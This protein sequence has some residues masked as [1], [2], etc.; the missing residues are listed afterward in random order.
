MQRRLL[1]AAAEQLGI[2]VDSAHVESMLAV[3]AGDVK[4]CE[5][6]GTW[7]V[8]RSFR[9]LRIEPSLPKP[10]NE[11]YDLPLPVPGSVQPPGMNFVVQAR[12][13]PWEASATRATLNANLLEVNAAGLRVRNWHA[14]DRFRP[15]HSRSEKKVKEILQELR[16]P[17]DERS[18]WPVVYQRD[19]LVW[20]RGARPLELKIAGEPQRLIIDARS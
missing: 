17:A 10:A 6:P 2:E 15:A 12:I 13:E 11:S 3:A 1:L 14:G 19:K 4:A 7:R 18:G 5:L 20:V 8:A 16:V 9:E